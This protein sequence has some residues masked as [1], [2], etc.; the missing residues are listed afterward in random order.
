[1]SASVQ[2]CHKRVQREVKEIVAC[3][4]VCLLN[5]LRSL[6]S[7]FQLNEHGVL[8]EVQNNNLVSAITLDS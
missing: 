3:K 6:M 1:M 4:D 7:C 5:Q 2:L 8:I